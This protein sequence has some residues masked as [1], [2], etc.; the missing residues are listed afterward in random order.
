MF[1][2]H[3]KLQLTVFESEIGDG[4]GNWNIEKETGFVGRTIV[5]LT[6]ATGRER[7]EDG[8]PCVTS[9]TIILFENTFCKTTTSFKQIFS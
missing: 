6:H 4:D 5:N 8:K 3:R 1:G 9:V 7:K 2:Y